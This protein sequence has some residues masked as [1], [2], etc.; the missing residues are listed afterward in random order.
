MAVP[1]LN[2]DSTTTACPKWPCAEHTQARSGDNTSASIA[3]HVVQRAQQSNVNQPSLTNWRSHRQ[4]R[5]EPIIQQATDQSPTPG[6]PRYPRGYGRQ[7][8]STEA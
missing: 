8:G 4:Q 7:H 1:P 6:L 2:G 3:A 5:A